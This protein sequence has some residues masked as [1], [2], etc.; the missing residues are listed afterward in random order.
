[1]PR[2]DQKYCF[3]IFDYPIDRFPSALFAPLPKMCPRCLAI[4]LLLSF[5]G[6][7]SSLLSQ[8]VL[9]GYR[10]QN[11]ERHENDHSGRSFLRAGLWYS[12]R[13]DYH[14]T[15]DYRVNQ[16]GNSDQEEIHYFILTRVGPRGL[17]ALGGTLGVGPR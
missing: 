12:Q 15:G 5:P 16:C 4:L 3:D 2:L 7:F 8:S 6:C 10:R 11:A 1:L 17:G 9:H 14:R 13:G